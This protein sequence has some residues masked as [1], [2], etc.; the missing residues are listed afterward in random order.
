MSNRVIK[1]YRNKIKSVMRDLVVIKKMKG[2][3]IQT[4]A[5]ERLAHQEVRTIF[6]SIF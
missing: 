2:D 1:G 6:V 5:T 4:L 3:W